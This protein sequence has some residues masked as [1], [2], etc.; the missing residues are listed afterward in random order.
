MYAVECVGGRY[1]GALYTFK[2][3]PL[4]IKVS[5]RHEQ[6][7]GAGELVIDDKE[8]A[9]V[10]SSKHTQE[11]GIEYYQ[12]H[13]MVTPQEYRYK[14]ITEKEYLRRKKAT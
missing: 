11:S 1:D 13:T 9:Q 8:V 10:T 3:L 2:N 12:Q 5:R 7:L 6:D 4:F 14:M